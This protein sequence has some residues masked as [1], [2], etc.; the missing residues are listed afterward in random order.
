MVEAAMKISHEIVTDLERIRDILIHCRKLVFD[1]YYMLVTK[2]S[3]KF[4][5]ISRDEFL[6]RVRESFWKL[7]IIELT[8]LY[9][10][11][12]QN[13]HYSIPALLKAIHS[14]Q[15]FMKD[16]MFL[17]KLKKIKHS[18]KTQD[19]KARVKKL[20]ELR[21]QHYAH[22]DRHPE[23]NIHNIKFYFEDFLHL[24]RLAE[25]IVTNLSIDFG[26]QIV[27]AEYEGQQ[28]N[29]FID[30]FIKY[31]NT[32]SKCVNTTQQKNK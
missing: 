6:V 29:D 2:T 8:K 24:L 15:L 10:S 9:G 1:S 14:S 5:T 25:N 26:I 7:A 18:I 3:E 16:N 27:F 4:T 28:M 13:D 22:T 23:N 30:R 20:L 19:T 17:D 32:H 21:N 11:N 12:G 31:R